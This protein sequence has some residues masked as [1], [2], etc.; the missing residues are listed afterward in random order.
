MNKTSLLVIST[1][2]DVTNSVLRKI[3][4]ISQWD[5]YGAAT[6]E[7]AIEKFHFMPADVVVLA[8]N[9]IKAEERKLRA[10]F[11]HQHPGIIIIL[12][13]EDEH[14]SVVNKIEGAIA[15]E[16]N[17]NRPS[18]TFVDDALKNAGLNISIQ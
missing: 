2:N 4:A 11:S 18:F 12:L 14:D 6:V 7:E 17:S 5:A 10:I 8:G 16:Q 1:N 3:N 13:P 15:E 9:G